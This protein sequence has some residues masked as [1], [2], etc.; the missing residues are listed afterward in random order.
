MHGKKRKE[1]WI[2]YEIVHETIRCCCFF[3]SF[4]CARVQSCCI[5]YLSLKTVQR[6]CKMLSKEIYKNSQLGIMN[7]G[8]VLL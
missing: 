5:S 1:S 4:V 3:P 7:T 6:I 8:T 2:C